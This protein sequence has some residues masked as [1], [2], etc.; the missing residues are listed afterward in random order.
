ME[1][2]EI[3]SVVET[4]MFIVGEPL[5]TED[6]KKVVNIGEMELWSALEI[7]E[8]KY[9]GDSGILLKRFGTK[10]QLCTNPKNSTK[11]SIEIE[12][13]EEIQETSIQEEQTP[14]IT[15]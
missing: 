5:E 14:K 15:L 7:L 8:Q 13:V 3:A 12:V 4:L 6:G 2:N 11:N 9:S 1:L 10:I